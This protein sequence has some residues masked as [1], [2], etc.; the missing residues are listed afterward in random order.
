MSKFGTEL[1]EAMQEALAHAQAHSKGEDVNIVI[2]N[3][4]VETVDAKAVRSKL[5]LT[6]EQ[7]ALMLG[8]SVSGY[9][10]WE[11]GQR[12]PGGAA[13]TLLRIMDQEP[14]AVLRVLAG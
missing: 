7:M 3:V 4:D 12:Q 8:T 9:R 2:H 14:Q 6:Q 13:R 5:K 10:K 11:Q 1:I